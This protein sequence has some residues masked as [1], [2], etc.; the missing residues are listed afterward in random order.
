MPMFADKFQKHKNAENLGWRG[1]NLPSF[2]SMTDEE[3]IEIIN[4]VLDFF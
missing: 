1:V 2:P 3:Q 4:S